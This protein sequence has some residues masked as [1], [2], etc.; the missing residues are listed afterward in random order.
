[1]TLPVLVLAGVGILAVAALGIL[2][3]MIIGIHRGDGRLTNAPA[4]HSDA[5]ARRMLTGVRLHG[6][7]TEGEDQ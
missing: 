6:G 3:V 5:F 4:S 2:A 1:M 7:N